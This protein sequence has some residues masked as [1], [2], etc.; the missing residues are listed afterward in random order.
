MML[1]MTN[2]DRI[3]LL[4]IVNNPPIPDPE[5][6]NDVITLDSTSTHSTPSSS[7]HRMMSKA[8]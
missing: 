6:K 7:S 3:S 5:N 2:S 8:S 1:M 4:D